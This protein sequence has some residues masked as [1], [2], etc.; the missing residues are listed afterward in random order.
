MNHLVWTGTAEL[1]A[2]LLEPSRENQADYPSPFAS[3]S[4]LRSS[5]AGSSLELP[6]LLAAYSV[7]LLMLFVVLQVLWLTP[8]DA[9]KSENTT[10]LHRIETKTDKITRYKGTDLK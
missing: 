7:S 1:L 2:E 9:Y 10:T 5:L 4:K 3:L 6:I 8:P